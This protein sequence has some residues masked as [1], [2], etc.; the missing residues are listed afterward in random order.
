M[1]GYS[2]ISG[3]HLLTIRRVHS[4]W[5]ECRTIA[6][7]ERRLWYMKYGYTQTQYINKCGW[8]ETKN[9]GRYRWKHL[10][11]PLGW[12]SRQA[13]LVGFSRR[14]D[15]PKV[16]SCSWARPRPIKSYNIWKSLRRQKKYLE[17]LRKSVPVQDAVEHGTL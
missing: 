16:W 10:D 5:H 9:F 17:A 14:Q 13:D 6:G 8:G 15:N 12:R 4:S 3:R 11:P 1:S 2:A 7:R